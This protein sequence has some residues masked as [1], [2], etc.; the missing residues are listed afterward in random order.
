MR[1]RSG[2]P[3]LGDVLD[4]IGTL[5]HTSQ[6][7][8]S[9]GLS[10]QGVEKSTIMGMPNQFLLGTSYDHGHVGYG[11]FSTLGFWGPDFVLTTFDPTIL[12]TA[13]LD[14]APRSLTTTNDYVGVYFSDTLDLTSQIPFH[15]WRALQ[16]RAPDPFWTTRQLSRSRWHSYLRALQPDDRHHLH[17][18][19]L[20]AYG[21][22]AE[23]NRA[24]T[25]AELACADPV[26][27]VLSKASSRPT[28][29]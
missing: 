13:P 14:S 20:T 5:D 17:I 18:P 3:G 2:R 16:F 26:I 9:W 28:R 15:R 22:Y 7:A 21:G 11:S 23:A 10:G 25:P 4:E 12:I 29:T 8:N 24:P 6:N 1:S 27:R 19:H